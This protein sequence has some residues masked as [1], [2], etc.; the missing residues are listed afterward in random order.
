[1]RSYAYLVA[2][3]VLYALIVVAVAFPPC[4]AAF[5]LL[6]LLWFYVIGYEA[7]AVVYRAPPG[8]GPAPSMPRRRP[9]RPLDAGPVRY[10]PVR[11]H[12]RRNLLA[13]RPSTRSHEG[14]KLV[15]AL[16]SSGILLGAIA[17]SARG[18]VSGAKAMRHAQYV[19][20]ASGIAEAQIEKL[21]A[22]PDQR[23]L[24]S[25]P[26]PADEL[27][28]LPGG[29]GSIRLAPYGSPGL[30]LIEVH[31]EWR[32]TPG[33]LRSVELTSLLPVGPEPPPGGLRP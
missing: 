29:R 21:R 14:Y 13:P 12:A 32:E 24:G 6:A 17:L 3:F 15:A 20:V 7:R 19:T 4:V 28:A 33:G 27:S 8:P 31:V 9:P 26:V 23:K 5:L 11:G 1:M 18:Y 10:V 30:R 16:I 22:R 25:R 2:A